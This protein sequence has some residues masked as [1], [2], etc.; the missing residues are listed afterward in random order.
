MRNWLILVVF[1]GSF[2]CNLTVSKDVL[3]PKKMQAVL[4][5]MMQADEMAE[6]YS[7][8][9]SSFKGIAN[10]IVYYQKIFAIYKITRETFTRS[11]GYY[12][13]HPA[14]LRPILDSLQH[15]G[16]RLQKSDTLT[17]KPA[18]S[19]STDSAKRK[20]HVRIHPM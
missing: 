5:D 16:Q 8:S 14:S 19:I 17:K 2:S 15:F 12:K 11:L 4:W 3:P 20:L 18:T 1:I 6:Y 13:D 10:R 7:S 9:D